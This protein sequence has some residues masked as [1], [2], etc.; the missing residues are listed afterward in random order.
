MS[1]RPQ[2]D[3]ET[4][5]VE[6]KQTKPKLYREAANEIN[7][8]LIS[9]DVAQKRRALMTSADRPRVNLGD[10]ESVKARTDDFLRACEATS[11]IPTFLGLCTA[12]GGSREWVYKY[13]RSNPG[14][15]SADFLE[16]TRETLADIMMTASLNKAADAATT[17]FSLKNL[18]GFVDKLEIAP[19]AED[20]GP[21]GPLED[22]EEL[23]RRIEAN[24]VDDYLEDDE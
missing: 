6:R 12:F 7:A 4:A 9:E 8:S 22:P 21:L 11:T 18:H 10:L 17:I 23:R 15:P 20:P 1:K 16:L 3:L 24:I 19:K 2:D 14:T 5:L 13:L